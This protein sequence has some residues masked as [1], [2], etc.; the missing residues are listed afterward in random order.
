MAAPASP[1]GIA[2]VARHQW[3]N[4]EPKMRMQTV[5]MYPTYFTYFAGELHFYAKDV[6]RG[7]SFDTEPYAPRLQIGM[8]GRLKYEHVTPYNFKWLKKDKWGNPMPDEGR[9]R[10][11]PAS[12]WI[13]DRWTFV[14]RMAGDELTQKLFYK[15]RAFIWITNDIAMGGDTQKYQD[16][17]ITEVF[18]YTD[19]KRVLEVWTT[20][21]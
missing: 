11:E 5:A 16:A 8:D 15:V 17:L 4:Q 6:L 3:E 20:S 21:N 7:P 19:K 10:F 13:E 9:V 2:K 18:G 1:E 14:R 12:V